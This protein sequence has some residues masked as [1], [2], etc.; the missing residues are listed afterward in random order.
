ML[1]RNLN[2]YTVDSAESVYAS[3]YGG[4]DG[5]QFHWSVPGYDVDY[6]FNVENKK[7]SEKQWY[8]RVTTPL[9]MAPAFGTAS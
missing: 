1:T 3:I 8:S 9:P 5:W 4:G 7:I 6:N 2:G